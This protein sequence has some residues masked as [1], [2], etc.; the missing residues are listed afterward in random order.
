[1][2]FDQSC[3]DSLPTASVDV[4][5]EVI[6]CLRSSELIFYFKVGPGSAAPLEAQQSHDV[7]LLSKTPSPENSDTRVS[8]GRGPILPRSW[9]LHVGV[10]RE[11]SLIAHNYTEQIRT[12]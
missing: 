6:F 12:G 11:H 1:M 10:D 8:L 3:L 2:S 7:C 4:A 9:V 5:L